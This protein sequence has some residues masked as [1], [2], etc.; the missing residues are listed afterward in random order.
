MGWT[1][2]VALQLGLGQDWLAM[3]S[4]LRNLLLQGHTDKRYDKETPGSLDSI[5]IE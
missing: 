5:V 3:V 4:S 1:G 2:V